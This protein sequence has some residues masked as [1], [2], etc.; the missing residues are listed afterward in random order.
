MISAVSSRRRARAAADIPP[1]TPPT[2][3]IRMGSPWVVDAGL[4]GVPSATSP[5]ITHTPGGIIPAGPALFSDCDPVPAC[6]VA[7][8]LASD[9]GRFWPDHSPIASVGRRIDGARRRH[10]GGY[11]DRRRDHS[12]WVGLG[13]RRFVA[14]DAGG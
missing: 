11:G 9:L 8:R 13:H 12:R 6:L 14:A 1:A 10:G 7:R 3:T 2:M 5:K 4:G